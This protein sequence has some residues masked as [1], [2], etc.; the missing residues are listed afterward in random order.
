MVGNSK[1]VGVGDGIRESGGIGVGSAVEW[2][3]AARDST[4]GTA[5][6]RSAADSGSKGVGARDGS[7]EGG[8]VGVVSAFEWSVVVR[9][10]A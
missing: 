8:G 4:S 3:S 9:A 5:V 6:A 1:G 7:G 10:E 2:L